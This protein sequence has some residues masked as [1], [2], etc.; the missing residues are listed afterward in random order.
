[1]PGTSKLFHGLNFVIVSNGNTD[2]S[3][4]AILARLKANGANECVVYHDEPEAIELRDTH[5][6]KQEMCRRFSHDVHAIIANT[7]DFWFYRVAAFDFLIPVV[8]PD[9]VEVCVSTKRITRASAFSTDPA[10]VLKNCQIYISRHSFNSSE[11]DFY[12][13]LI[14]ALGGLCIDYLSSRASHIVTKD[15]QDPAITAVANIKGLS[16]KY[17]LPTWAVQTF[18]TGQYVD[19][20][21]HVLNPQSHPEDVQKQATKVWKNMEVMKVESPAMF[22]QN[23]KFFLSLDLILPSQCYGFFIDLIQSAGG[24]VIRHIQ[25][26]D[27]RRDS[28]NCFVGQSGDSE[29]CLQ[30]SEERLHIGNIS[31]VFQM[32]SMRSFIIPSEKLLLSPLRPPVFKKNELI[33]GYTTY[34]GQQRQYIQ[35]IVNALGGVS[36]TEFTRKNTHLLTCFPFGQKYEAA[37]RWKDS[38]KIVNH[39]WLED[40]YKLQASLPSDKKTYTEIPICGGLATRL[41]QMPLVT[42]NNN[43]LDEDFTDTIVPQNSVDATSSKKQLTPVGYEDEAFDL[44]LP[45]QQEVDEFSSVGN[46]SPS[47]NKL[48][49]QLNDD[50]LMSDTFITNGAMPP[51]SQIGNVLG[52][53]QAAA[54]S[55]SSPAGQLTQS[56]KDALQDRDRLV[57]QSK[58][59]TPEIDLPIETISTPLAGHY[60]VLPGSEKATQL[61]QHTISSPVSE[62]HSQL[63]SSGNSRRAKEKAAKKL[64]T[65]MEA[66]N[67]FQQNLKRKRNG[68]LLPEELQKLKQLKK[69]EDKVRGLLD[70]MNASEKPRGKNKRPYDIVA[71]CTGCHEAIDEWDLELLKMLGVT[72]LNTIT[73]QCNAIIAPKKLRTAKFLTS[74]SFH[75]LKYALLPDFLTSVLALMQ[76]DTPGK[77]L[78]D[79]DEYLIPDLDMTV[80]EKTHLQ[81]KVFQRAGIV[82]INITDDVPGGQEVLSS[83]LKAHGVQHIQVL[84]KKFTENDISI[85]SNKKKSPTHVLVA[86]KATQAKRFGKLCSQG[87][88]ED[89]VLVVEWNWCVNSIFRLDVDFN[90]S[91]F[92][93]YRS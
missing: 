14:Q 45:V 83:I 64:H 16:I 91:E 87:Q 28:G 69:L 33:V 17:V 84:P 18:I 10:H 58:S 4:D 5:L 34:L 35:K 11:Y 23:H 32:W 65:D 72:I 55:D 68:S 85:N 73:P 53:K 39:L 21:A 36:T 24:D 30:A 49:G 41:G 76:D 2:F 60:Q 15:A 77:N 82:S 62:V 75:P 86:Q 71:V 63:M 56:Y 47:M 90:A 81:S 66:L 38:C 57:E 12:S 22:L 92:V 80:L 1:M 13:A 61:Q 54:E 89:N 46:K 19:E 37:V 50:L 44:D 6:A 93:V 25:H 48:D 29:E 8:N 52:I 88:G 26:T 59:H 70:N 31:W 74:L 78:P 43:T 42:P 20:A 27:I 9:W 67:E 7:S 51:S 79:V 40:C 3:V